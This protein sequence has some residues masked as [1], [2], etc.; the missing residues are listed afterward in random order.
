MAVAPTG[1]IYKA[2][3]FDNTSSRNYGVYITGQ[4]V[5][6]APQRDVE[7][8]TIPGRNGTF[9]LDNGRFENVEVTYPAGIFADNEEDFAEAISD[10][11]NFLCSRNGYV[12]L[13]DDYNPNEYRMAIYK[14]G[15]EVEPSLLR[16]GE[17]EIIFDC[18][19]QRWL[20]SG[21]EAIDV[22]SGDVISNPTL[23]EASPL[24]EVKGE[25]E[26]IIGGESISINN[27][28]LGIIALTAAS[29]STLAI[30]TIEFDQL[31]ENGDPIT[32]S[33]LKISGT[34]SP[35]STT[36]A[37][38][39]ISGTNGLTLS[40]YISTGGG[41][42]TATLDDTVLT[43]GTAASITASGAYRLYF[44]N[45]YNGYFQFGIQL[46]Y[47]GN[48][49]ITVER[50]VT[51]TNTTYSRA[52][53]NNTTIP[54]IYGDSSKGSLGNP[55]YIDL[56]IGEAW[57]EDSGFPVST[58]NAVILPSNLP[59]LMAGSTVITFDNTIT[60]LKIIPRWW[61]V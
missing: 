58:N 44:N 22:D 20:T 61:R 41:G 43:F 45:G 38:A 26:I 59:K 53:S 1:A 33:G 7:M 49:T 11:R 60:D 8:I 48:T 4:A 9:A 32:I 57:N 47:D 54:A 6:N 23:F 29:E 46:D 37:S 17:F 3:K 31:L 34:V 56:D 21:E 19:P 2:L 27:D 10:F 36:L 30:T 12:R 39:Q 14:S 18:K 24:L 51:V 42:A 16:A 40:G 5:F 50:T 13:Q 55:M 28:P 25:G 35:K 52:N 15:L